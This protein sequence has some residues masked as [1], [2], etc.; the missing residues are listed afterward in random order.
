MRTFFLITLLLACGCTTMENNML[1][2]PSESLYYKANK[3]YEDKEFIAAI[4]LYNEFLEAK[5]RSD[6]AVSAQL[7]LGMSYY[8]SVDYKQAYLTLKEVT[9][10]DENI[11]T[12]VTGI[13]KICKAEAG[14]AIETEKK[15]KLA[16]ATS[17]SKASQVKIEVTDAYVDDF[18]S[19]V[20]R[21]K[22][23][24][25]ATVTVDRE[26]AALDGNNVFT[27]SVT[28]KKGRPISVT[29]K[30]E[31]G[32]LSEFNYFPDRENPEEPEGLNSINTSSNSIEIEW[33]ENSEDDIKGYR[34]F[35]RLKGGSTKEVPDLIE[36]TKYEVVGLQ[37]HVE[38][39]NR[40]FQF[41]LKAIDK[42]NNESDDSDILEVDLP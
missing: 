34:L 27:A 23:N 4:N 5:P 41:Y 26:K 13:L 39:A 35:Y 30:D 16:V 8:Y 29:A 37:G 17:Q 1:V 25:I 12:Y 24:R 21:G 19:V 42:M 31:G 2:S 22:T 38:G 7:N 14:D 10:E 11:K 18:G 36:D 9:V 40:T 6:L 28:W 32:G 3:S 20:L 15:T 33:D